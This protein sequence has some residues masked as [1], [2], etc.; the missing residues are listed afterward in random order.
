[1]TSW[2]ITE[3]GL[4]IRRTS[5]SINIETHKYGIILYIYYGL[6]THKYGTCIILGTNITQR[7]LDD[8]ITSQL[9]EHKL[10]LDERETERGTRKDEKD[11]DEAAREARNVEKEMELQRRLEE[12]RREWEREQDMIEREIERERLL[13]TREK[14]EE[15]TLKKSVSFKDELVDEEVIEMIVMRTQ[16]V[17]L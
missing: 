9:M 6:E 16:T 7:E 12:R 4:R 2:L 14:Q 15:N 5:F 13:K 8:K 11:I 10:L 1:M 17:Q 3:L